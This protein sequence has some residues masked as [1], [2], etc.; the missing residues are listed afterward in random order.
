M[1]PGERPHSI[2]RFSSRRQRLDQS[3]LTQRLQGARAYDRIA[4][5]FRSSILEVA[6]EALESV[7]GQ[8]RIVCNSGLKA[9]DIVTARAAAAALRQDWC[10]SQPELLVEAGESQPRPASHGCTRF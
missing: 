8:V 3:F 10:A 6:G 2:R 1:D 9:G 4:G 5:Y 7:R